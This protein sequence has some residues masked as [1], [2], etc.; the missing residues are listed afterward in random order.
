MVYLPGSSPF[1]YSPGQEGFL[2]ISIKDSYHC[3]CSF[4]F[5]I[6]RAV[7]PEPSIPVVLVPT[8]NHDNNQHAANEN[9]RLGNYFEGI[10]L[11]NVL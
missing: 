4:Q 8:V 6:R 3:Y 7:T 5:V 2:N 10:T 9:I 11:I 1:F